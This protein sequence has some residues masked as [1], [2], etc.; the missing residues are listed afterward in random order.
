MDYIEHF[1]VE[2]CKTNHN[3]QSGERKIPSR[4]NEN[5]S[6]RPSCQKRGKTRQTSC[7][8]FLK[9]SVLYCRTENLFV[10]MSTP[11]F[12]L[13][14]LLFWTIFIIFIRCAQ[15]VSPFISLQPMLTQLRTIFDLIIQFQNAQE[16]FFSAATAEL[17]SRQRLEKAVELR[18]DEV[19]S[20]FV[21]LNCQTSWR[22]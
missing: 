17:Q 18:T 11:F 5:W 8:W 7:D 20:C 21:S 10:K 6:N 1:S 2:C 19:R 4:T 9:S 16:S 15:G 3:S 14:I 13:R 22:N 12:I